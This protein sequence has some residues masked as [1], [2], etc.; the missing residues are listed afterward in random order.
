MNAYVCINIHKYTYAGTLEKKI[1]K[2]GLIF[3]INTYIYVHIRKY[4]HTHI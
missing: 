4:I 2:E 1:V 3:A